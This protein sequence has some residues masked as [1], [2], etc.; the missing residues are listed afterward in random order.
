MATIAVVH[1]QTEAQHLVGLVLNERWAPETLLCWIYGE[2]CEYT[3]V[4]R[5]Y[6]NGYKIVDVECS[7][8]SKLRFGLHGP[9][10]LYV[11]ETCN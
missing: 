4:R 5:Q 10:V 7:D 2:D 8:E 1:E 6:P 3:I 11:H 9:E